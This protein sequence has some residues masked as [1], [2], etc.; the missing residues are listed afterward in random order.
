MV[1]RR[2]RRFT[3]EFKAAIVRRVRDGEAVSDV[4]RESE[5]PR[6]TIYRWLEAAGVSAD[7]KAKSDR[8]ELQRMRRRLRELEMENE[9]LKKAEAFFAKRRT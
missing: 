6:Q 4:G 3:P 2:R 8:T 9:I 5:L 7:P 1:K